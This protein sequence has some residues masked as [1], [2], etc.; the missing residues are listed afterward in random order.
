MTKENQK[1]AYN[2]YFREYDKQVQRIHRMWKPY[3]IDIWKNECKDKDI[4]EIGCGTAYIL[5][6]LLSSGIRFKSYTGI[7]IADNIIK[8]N[9]KIYKSDNI[10]F[11]ADD[12]ER[13]EKLRDNNF[14]V[15][16][17][18]GCLHHLE[19]PESAINNLYK[20]LKD[21]GELFAIEM[22]RKYNEETFIGF[23]SSM[24]GLH[25]KTKDKVSNNEYASH[26]PGHPA[27]R[28]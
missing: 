18:Y 2:A 14:D 11:I 9:S 4:L 3:T 19:N 20:K 22:N 12:A 21:N 10:T 16:I 24:L 25:F 26:H 27:S 15:V 5:R 7:D 23:Y 13:L 8:D 17:S 6:E 28:I 1:M